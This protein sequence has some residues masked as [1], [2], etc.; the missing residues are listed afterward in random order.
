MLETGSSQY[1][2]IEY[3]NVFY[4]VPNGK[5]DFTASVKL[6]LYDPRHLNVSQHVLSHIED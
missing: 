5:L 2:T 3:L 4:C 1:S 6:I